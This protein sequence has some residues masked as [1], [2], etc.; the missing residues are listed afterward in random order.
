MKEIKAEIVGGEKVIKE[1][2]KNE[3]GSIYEESERKVLVDRILHPATATSRYEP[4][5]E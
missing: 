5:P 3:R 1:S 4:G 2:I